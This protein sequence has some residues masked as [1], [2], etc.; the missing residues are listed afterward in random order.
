MIYDFI[1]SLPAYKELGKDKC[2]QLVY[3]AIQEI[4]SCNDKQV[5]KHL[6]WPINRVTPRRGELVESGLVLQEK[7]QQD[8]ES[9]R[10]VSYWIVNHKNS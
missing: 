8:P 1:S 6:N 9:G 4:G 5:A 7:K 10:T 3:L 2:R